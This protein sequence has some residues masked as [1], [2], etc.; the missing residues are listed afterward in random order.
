M[1][2]NS[3]RIR[4]QG[5]GEEIYKKAQERRLEGE[6]SERVREMANELTLKD[7]M[8]ANFMN[9]LEN[10]PTLINI[11]TGKTSMLLRQKPT[12]DEETIF[13]ENLKMNLAANAKA[14]TDMLLWMLPKEIEVCKIKINTDAK[15]GKIYFEDLAQELE[16]ALLNGATS[17]AMS[18][19]KGYMRVGEG[20][21]MKIEI[22]LSGK[23]TAEVKEFADRLKEEFGGEYEISLKVKM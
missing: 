19:S 10:L 15:T 4:E 12:E 17:R 3:P 22:E 2:K 6:K 11:F 23:N 20:G 1:R 21:A 18:E 14:I 7:K 5:A 13:L 9:A 8:L 16:N